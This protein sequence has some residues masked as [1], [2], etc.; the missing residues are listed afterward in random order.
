MAKNADAGKVK[1]L[2]IN[3]HKQGRAPPVAGTALMLAM[4]TTSIEPASKAKIA[5]TA[6]PKAL[7]PW[8]QDKARCRLESQGIT[9]RG[10]TVSA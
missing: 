8:I 2:C 4:A 6:K 10:C 7:V 5:S 1:P 9:T 3:M